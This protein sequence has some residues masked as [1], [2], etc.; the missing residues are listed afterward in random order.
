MTGETSKNLFGRS[1]VS[2]FS[3]QHAVSVYIFIYPW[4]TTELQGPS[5]PSD[6][7]MRPKTSCFD[8]DRE[9]PLLLPS[10]NLESGNMTEFTKI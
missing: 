6:L 10:Y 8:L 7:P 5:S 3:D 1:I 9:D 2:V 4:W